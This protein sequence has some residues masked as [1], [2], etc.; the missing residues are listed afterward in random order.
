LEYCATIGT[1]K[2][3]EVMDTEFLSEAQRQYLENGG[4][5][6]SEEYSTISGPKSSDPPPKEPGTTPSD[7][8]GGDLFELVHRG[9][10]KQVDR[11]KIVEL[12]QKGFDYEEKS[13]TLKEQ[14]QAEANRL[15]GEMVQSGKLGQPPIQPAEPVKPSTVEWPRLPT[16][17]YGTGYPQGQP[18]SPQYEYDQFGNLIPVQPTQT[19]HKTELLMNTVAQL[20][21]ALDGMKN[22]SEKAEVANQERRL[23]ALLREGQSQYK[24]MNH[25]EVLYEIMANPLADNLTDL[26]ILKICERS[27]IDHQTEKDRTLT[28]YLNKKSEKTKGIPPNIPSGTGREVPMPDKPL[29]NFGDARLAAM[30]YLKKI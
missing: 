30:E 13:R 12:A 3:E 25:K 15:V 6:N 1:H 4:D 14:I 18:P 19:D 22:E 21:G 27:H 2:S 24:L 7:V 28:E 10:K 23:N 20:Q 29:K 17:P 11:G 8:T 9:E 5:P 26:D 16:S